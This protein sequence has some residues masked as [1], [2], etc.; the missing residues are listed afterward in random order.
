MSLAEMTAVRRDEALCFRKKN[1]MRNA[2]TVLQMKRRAM[3]A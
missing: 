3:P 2:E 1:G